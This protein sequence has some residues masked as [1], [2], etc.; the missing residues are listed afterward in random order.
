MIIRNGVDVTDEVFRQVA[1]RQQNNPLKA[2]EAIVHLIKAR[3]SLNELPRPWLFDC[4]YDSIQQI[5][6]IIEKLSVSREDQ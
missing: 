1:E 6:A 2:D 5:D 4:I 3:N